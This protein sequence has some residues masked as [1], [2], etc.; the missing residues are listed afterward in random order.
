MAGTSSARKVSTP[1]AGAKDDFMAFP[2]ALNAVTAL[3]LD[4][5]VSFKHTD[6][7][8]ERGHERKFQTRI[9]PSPWGICAS[10]AASA[11]FRM[12]VPLF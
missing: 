6:T 7:H 4:R 11:V 9:S 12:A 10:S 3:A 1:D 8:C 5:G 2:A